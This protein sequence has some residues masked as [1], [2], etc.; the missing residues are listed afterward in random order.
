[1][2]R[3]FSQKL[4]SSFVGNM[5]IYSVGTESV[6]LI[7]QTSRIECL[8]G[9]SQEGLTHE[10]LMRHSCLHPVLTLCILVM[11]KAHASLRGKLNRE[12]PARTL[13]AL[14]A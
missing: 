6:Y 12:I 4:S 3:V 5:G 2:A 9:V 11:C 14:I 8:A 13:L 7:I 10:I 1:M